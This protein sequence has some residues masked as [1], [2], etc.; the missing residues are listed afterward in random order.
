MH[1]ARESGSAMKDST[2]LNDLRDAVLVGGDWLD[3]WRPYDS[4]MARTEHYGRQWPEYSQAVGQADLR[5]GW[6]NN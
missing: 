3:N 6:D 5:S 4:Y 2:F 1:C